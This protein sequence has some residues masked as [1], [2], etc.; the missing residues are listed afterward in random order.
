LL[1]GARFGP[2]AEAARGSRFGRACRSAVLGLGRAVERLVISLPVIPGPDDFALTVI[3]HCNG[4]SRSATRLDLDTGRRCG[5]TEPRL[6]F[7]PTYSTCLRPYRSAHPVSSN[8]HTGRGGLW[9]PDGFHDPKLYELSPGDDKHVWLIRLRTRDEGSRLLPRR[10]A[11]A[12][13][14]HKRIIPFRSLWNIPCHDDSFSRNFALGSQ[15]H[16]NHLFGKRSSRDPV[17]LL[18]NSRIPTAIFTR[19]LCRGVVA[20]LKSKEK[21]PSIVL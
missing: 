17:I 4:Y 2:S 20:L 21:P 19:I 7:H 13:D 14:Q 5:P 15:H 16:A 18:Q 6:L 8:D 12:G 11:A 9:V 1:R 10:A 3:F